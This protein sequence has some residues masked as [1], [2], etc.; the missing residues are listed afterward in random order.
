MSRIIEEIILEVSVNANK[1]TSDLKAFKGE[2]VGLD[3]SLNNSTASTKNLTGS[4][5]KLGSALLAT[6]GA[7]ASVKKASDTS[8]EFVKIE[9]ALTSVF[10]ESKKVKSEWEFLNRVSETLGMNVLGISKSYAQLA[11]ATNQTVLEGRAT[12]DIFM[13]VSTASTALSLSVDEVEG[14][15]R[16]FT[17][18][19]SKG[20]VQAEELRGQIGDRLPGAFQIAARAMNTTT[21]ELS[22]MLDEGKLFSDDFMPKFAKQL[23]D[24]FAQGALAAA[25]KE[26]ASLNR[27]S[28]ELNETWR[29]FG[30]AANS[31]LPF[32]ADTVIPA[33]TNSF[34]SLLDTS[35]DFAEKIL[36][37]IILV[38]KAVF[39]GLGNVIMSF[40]Q[41]AG[42]VLDTIG[43]GWNL[44][45]TQITGDE[46]WVDQ[47]TLG[48]TVAA[49]AWPQ[50]ISNAFLKI[51]KFI[52][53]ILD[54]IARGFDVVTDRLSNILLEIGG[55]LG[56]LD[57]ETVK[58]ATE[59]EMVNKGDNFF[60]SLAKEQ[61][62]LIQENN[63]VIDTF[64][65][66]AI[67]DRKKQRQ[68]ISGL[69]GEI[70]KRINFDI[71][72]INRGPVSRR[73]RAQE[74]SKKGKGKSVSAATSAATTSLE[75]GTS[76]A[77]AF[78]QDTKVQF[79]QLDAL[80]QIEKNTQN[81]LKFVAK[82]A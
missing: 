41:V 77:S 35:L 78:L 4:L 14:V 45:F 64:A 44:I 27:I 52:S 36:P 12:R 54:Q 37:E 69:I 25:N 22:K 47:I 66:I 39:E 7:I 80:K 33:V 23:K 68:S 31:F 17:Q 71:K 3:N 48:L 9:N 51:G 5:L 43:E 60:S 79:E 72:G 38:G 19:I 62:R 76:A 28:N 15:M 6:A 18:I 63:E 50:L 65:K 13:A 30:I 56:L 26:I 75:V 10:Q 67:E 16:A 81:R 49:R 59:I 32:I 21:Q 11:A 20:K 58:L 40:A 1:S 55:E 73:E 82:G 29:Q 61:E 46:N 2:V 24:E 70:K 42:S 53:Q 57:K 34:E 74:Q 8:L